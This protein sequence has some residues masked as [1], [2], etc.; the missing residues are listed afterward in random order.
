MVSDKSE[1]PLK[2]RRAIVAGERSGQVAETSTQWEEWRA[3]A[4]DLKARLRMHL[5]MTKSAM[6]RNDRLMS[7]KLQLQKDVEARD[8][9]LCELRALLA[10]EK[11]ARMD[12]ENKA[13]AALAEAREAELA[14]QRASDAATEALTVA[15]NER[16]LAA[17]S[18][19]AGKQHALHLIMAK[20][21]SV[22]DVSP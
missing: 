13:A 8:A 6:K 2:A 19:V 12:A 4:K 10:A 15:D 9:Q 16:E 17:A 18:Y 14:R 20:K 22:S 3:E 5:E 7:E 11:K 21:M 1:S